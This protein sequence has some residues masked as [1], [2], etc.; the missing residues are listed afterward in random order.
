[1]ER[2]LVLAPLLILRQPYIALW[3]I[4]VLSSVTALQRALYVR[5]QAHRQSH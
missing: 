4:A 2:F 5:Q 1:M 3:I